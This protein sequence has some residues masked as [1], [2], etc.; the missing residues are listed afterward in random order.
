MFT[1]SDFNRTM[2]CGRNSARITR[3]RTGGAVRADAVDEPAF[4][5]EGLMLA[6]LGTADPAP[7]TVVH[8]AQRRRQVSTTSSTVLGATDGQVVDQYGLRW[9]IGYE[10]SLTAHRR[11]FHK[12]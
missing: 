3:G 10:A 7:P 2:P 5:S 9:L 12:G 6:L 4:H 8:A 1:L 11:R